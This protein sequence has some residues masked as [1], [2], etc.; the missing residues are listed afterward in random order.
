M[1]SLIQELIDGG[2]LKMPRIIEAFREIDRADFVPA[3]LQDEAY[4]N[5]PL[6]IGFGQTISQPLTVA[7]MLELLQ[8]QAGEKIL[9]VGAGS[10]W[11]TA[12]LSHIASAE[13]KKGKVIGV[14]RIRELAEMAEK[15]VS[16]YN[17]IGKGIAKIVCADGSQGFKSEAPFDKI[18]AGA[19]G[20]ELPVAW[21]K[22]LRTGG[23]I[24]TPIR[25]S[26]FVFDRIPGGEFSAG[27]GPASGWKEKEYFG[28]RF[29]PLIKDE[30]I[31]FRV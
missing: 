21:K 7:F 16:K 9:D 11:T 29:V 14:E 4:G 17:F 15:N 22:Q 19:A 3:E 5:Y 23:R 6:A 25:D 1:E 28:F 18:I 12:L 24:V 8:P 2:Y 13:K 20:E 10:G 27:G 26:V 30:G 31:G